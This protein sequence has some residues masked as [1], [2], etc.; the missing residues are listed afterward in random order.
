MQT[1]TSLL[2]DGSSTEDA[3]Q[4]GDTESRQPSTG[5][6]KDTSAQSFVGLK[7]KE[8]AA[9]HSIKSMAIAAPKEFKLELLIW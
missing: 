2:G 7:Q 4:D 8:S 3:P 1:Q 6:K 9:P 5:G